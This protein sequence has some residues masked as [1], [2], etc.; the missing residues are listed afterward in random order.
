M[1]TDQLI[2]LLASQAAAVRP[3]PRPSV[4]LLQW[5]AVSLPATAVGVVLVQPRS[6]LVA[7]L[8]DPGFAWR[9]VATL[10]TALLAAAI[11][12]VLSVPGRERFPF[13]RVLPFIAAG[14]WVLV[15]ARLLVEGGNSM[16]RL[17]ALPVHLGC[18]LQMTALSAVPTATLF[19]MLRR[20]APMHPGWNA[21]L[22]ALAG[23]ALAALGTQALCPLDDPAHQLVGHVVPV[24]VLTGIGGVA[25][26]H[27]LNWS[28]DL[29][30]LRL[31]TNRH[32]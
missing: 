24:L 1:R 28:A 29:R 2:V 23:V 7:M 11:A 15:L 10:A 26:R 30:N 16:A 25:L 6:D 3:L 20:A 8:Y 19:A 5:I 17:G 9:A 32:R 14:L 31:T 22:A 21:V 27:R 4:R 18:I 12:L 13:G